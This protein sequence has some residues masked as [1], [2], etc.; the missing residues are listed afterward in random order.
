MFGNAAST[1]GAGGIFGNAGQSGTPAGEF[2]LHILKTLLSLTR[3]AGTQPAFGAG[4]NL[5]GNFGAN[6][7]AAPAAPT[8]GTGGGNLFGG[9][10]S[11]APATGPGTSG[12]PTFSLPGGSLFGGPKP[13]EQTSTA[14][15]SNATPRE[16]QSMSFLRGF[17]YLRS[18]WSTCCYVVNK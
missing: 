18:F 16:Y 3:A 14:S 8:I 9:A 12:T 4:N 5:F 11:T 7:G 10:S 17:S 13:A 2:S 15:T 1:P 6:R